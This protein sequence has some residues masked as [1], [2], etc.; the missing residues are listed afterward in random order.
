MTAICDHGTPSIRWALR[1]ASTINADS[2]CGDAATRTDT[3]PDSVRL[4]TSS[5]A[6]AAPGSRRATPAMAPATAGAQRCDSVSV[7][8]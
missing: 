4:P 1:S 3:E 7:I 8:T 5:R 6:C 2:A